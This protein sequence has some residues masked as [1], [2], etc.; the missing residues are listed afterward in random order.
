MKTCETCG[1][2]C[3]GGGE[4]MTGQYVGLRANNAVLCNDRDRQAHHLC[5][6]CVTD[7]F[8]VIGHGGWFTLTDK[9]QRQIDY[10][11]WRASRG[12]RPTRPFRGPAVYLESLPSH[13]RGC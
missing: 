13:C 12:L 4:Q 11:T 1:K 2:D 7:G 10:Q 5:G 6:H 3:N 9:G 8:G